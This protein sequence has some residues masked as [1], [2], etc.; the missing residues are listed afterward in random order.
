MVAVGRFGKTD[1]PQTKGAASGFGSPQLAFGS[2][3]PA[4][5]F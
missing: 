1:S 5:S 2:L 4:K 3:I